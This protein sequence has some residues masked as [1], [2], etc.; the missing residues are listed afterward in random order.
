MRKLIIALAIAFI[1]GFFVP[2]V[3]AAPPALD[4]RIEQP[5]SPT[6]IN[7][8]KVNFVALDRL[9]RDI[10]VQCYK[11][12]PSD[13]GFTQFGATITLS[14]GGNTANCEPNTVLASDGT[15]E[16]YAFATAGSDTDFSPTVTVDYN[17]SGPGTPT[18]YSK[19]HPTSCTYVIKF[20]TADDAGKTVRADLYRS[21]ATSFTADVAHRVDQRFIGSNTNVEITNT[22]PDCAKTYYYAVRAFDS[23]GNGSGIVGDSVVTVTTT[24]S[25][26]TTT[27]TSTTT[28]ATGT[29]QG[30]VQTG[31]TGG[32]VLGTETGSGSDTGAES[33]GSVLGEEAT[34]S[35]EIAETTAAGVA[36]PSTSPFNAKNI[37]IGGALLGGILL[38]A[39]LLRKRKPRTPSL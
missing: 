2:P 20:R 32:N 27:T 31:N 24:S 3:F 1:F 39:W 8:L 30:A 18:N 5:K 14:A 23:A 36:T 9:G 12:G 4:I 19:D 29:N 37:T 21:D 11:K 16:F 10:T 13:G 25:T 38:L 26:T 22:V 33:D 7:N 17:T 35:P 28:G 34:P 15:Y 6:N